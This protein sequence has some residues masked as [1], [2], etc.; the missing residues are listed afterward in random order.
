MGRMQ[1]ELVRPAGQR[2][3]QDPGCSSGFFQALPAGRPGLAPDRIIDLPGPVIGVEPEGK[4]YFTL[5]S[6][7]PPLKQGFIPFCYLT[8]GKLHAQL[9]MG[10]FCQGKNHET[11]GRHV[12]TVYCRL[13]YATGKKM[14]NPCS[15]TILLL[16]ATTGY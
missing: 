7:Y 6:C 13:I 5:L 11:G 15:H 16:R 9:S 12:Q 2:N 3:K 8:G 4:G 14:F 10:R 1:T